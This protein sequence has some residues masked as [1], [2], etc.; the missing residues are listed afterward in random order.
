M[1][2][3]IQNLKTN[4]IIPF[5]TNVTMIAMDEQHRRETLRSYKTA[6][7]AALKK[8][9]EQRLREIEEQRLREIEEQRLREIEEQRLR[10]EDEKSKK[11]QIK[12]LLSEVDGCVNVF[13]NV[14]D[15]FEKKMKKQNDLHEE[16]MKKSND[17]FD[18]KIKDLNEFYQ[19]K[20]DRLINSLM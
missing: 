20:F 8:V 9:D 13:Y 16:Q 3:L 7:E 14:I 12:L 2:L 4:L 5:V 17:L 10:D 6:E 11:E 19:T 18:K 15:N 1:F